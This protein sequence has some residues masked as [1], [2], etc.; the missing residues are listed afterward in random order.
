MNKTCTNCDRQLVPQK[1]WQALPLEERNQRRAAGQSYH[2]ARNLCANCYDTVRRA[3]ALIDHETVTQPATM[4][5]EEW[6]RMVD[7]ER[8]Q[9]ENVRLI[10]PRLGMTE[11]A[12]LAQVLRA[13]RVAA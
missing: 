9:N 2:Q 10:A 3:G 8:S 11:A 5:L 4:V 12:L 7:R 6:D 13:K 1:V